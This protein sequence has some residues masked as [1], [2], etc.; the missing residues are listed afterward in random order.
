M[1]LQDKKKLAGKLLSEIQREEEKVIV[2][3]LKET[4]KVGDCFKYSNSYSGDD[5]W[6]LYQK[7]IKVDGTFMRTESIQFT[8]DKSL[9]YQPRDLMV[10]FNGEVNSSYYPIPRKEYETAKAR[11]LKKIN[12]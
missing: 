4:V 8:S 6:W 1:K 10:G 5:R 2:A 12:K 3:K 7:V 9:I 11:I